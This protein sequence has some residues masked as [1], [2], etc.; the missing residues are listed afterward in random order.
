MEPFHAHH[1]PEMPDK[2]PSFFATLFVFLGA[3]FG[4][5]FPIISSG[6]ISSG[7]SRRS[8][9]S[10]DRVQRQ[11]ESITTPA[12]PSDESGRRLG[13]RHALFFLAR[14]GHRLRSTTRQGVPA[15]VLLPVALLAFAGITKSAQ[16]PSHLAAAPWS[17][18]PPFRPLLH[19]STMVNAGVYLVLRMSPV[20]Q[21][22]AAGLLWPWWAP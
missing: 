10:G 14:G 1:F 18:P 16:C 11:C 17:P 5:V 20:L 3:M 15:A 19:S 6:S 22:T 12:A 7:R 21:H 13:F 9:R 4:L 2:R 8:V